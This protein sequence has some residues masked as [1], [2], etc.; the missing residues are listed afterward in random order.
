MAS[1]AAC[2][3][4]EA[5][6]YQATETGTLAKCRAGECE[7]CAKLRLRVIRQSVYE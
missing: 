6:E 7:M 1:T 2:K 5:P 3:M 4:H